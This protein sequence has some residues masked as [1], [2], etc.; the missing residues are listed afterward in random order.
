[1]LARD[2][3][4]A[5]DDIAGKGARRV[6]EAQDIR[7]AV[8]AAVHAIEAPAFRLRDVAHRDEGRALQCGPRPFPQPRI[9]GNVH[10][11]RRA[12]DRDPRRARRHDLFAA[13]LRSYASTMAC[14]SGWRTTS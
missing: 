8:M 7:R 9:V 11:T 13:S 4:R 10:G 3:R 12:L 5:D 14:T 1:R 6:D 2:D